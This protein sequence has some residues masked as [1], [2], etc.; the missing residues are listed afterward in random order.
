VEGRSPKRR[1]RRRI[2][3]VGEGRRLRRCIVE[4]PLTSV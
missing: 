4:I 3:G 1:S 2:G